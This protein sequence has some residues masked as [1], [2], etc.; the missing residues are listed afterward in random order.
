[1]NLKIRPFRK[2]LNEIEIEGVIEGEQF[3]L[4]LFGRTYPVTTSTVSVDKHG[5]FAFI[6]EIERPVNFGYTLQIEVE[7]DE[8]VPPGCRIAIFRDKTAQVREVLRHEGIDPDSGN[9]VGTA[10]DGVYVYFNSWGI[11]HG[12]SESLP[13]PIPADNYDM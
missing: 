11:I 2:T 1:M 5:P 12:W 7:P 9:L 4:R 8:D 13:P 6:D 3:R 10:S